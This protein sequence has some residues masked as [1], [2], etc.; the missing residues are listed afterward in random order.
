MSKKISTPRA[1]LWLATVALWQIGPVLKAA[2]NTW[3]GTTADWTDGANW[4]STL[5][6]IVSD[7]LVFGT[8]TPGTINVGLGSL[9]NSLAF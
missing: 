1:A 7:D 5:A 2:P 8:G 6:P 3:L 4:S 9:A